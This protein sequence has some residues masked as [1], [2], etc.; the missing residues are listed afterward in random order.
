MDLH[1]GARI[2]GA[3]INGCHGQL[4]YGFV[5]GFDEGKILAVSGQGCHNSP[6]RLISPDSSCLLGCLYLTELLLPTTGCHSIVIRLRWV[7]FRR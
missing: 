4:T 6:K 3:H 7:D 2:N 5:Q 1:L